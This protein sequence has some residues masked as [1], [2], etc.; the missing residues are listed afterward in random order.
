MSRIADIKRLKTKLLTELAQKGD[1]RR[2]ALIFLLT[3]S[4]KFSYTHGMPVKAPITEKALLQR[5]NRKLRAQDE[6][7]KRAR[8]TVETTLGAY[9]VVDVQGNFVKQHHVDIEDF[10]RDLGVLAE[11]ESLQ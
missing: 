2:V 1:I 6:I 4:L 7:L 9:F 8:S 11:W 10:G 5:I 3:H